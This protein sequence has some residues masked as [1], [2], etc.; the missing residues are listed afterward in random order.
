M[1][2]ARHGLVVGKFYPPHAGHHLLIRA[3]AR[4]CERV[5]VAVLGSSV[6]TMPLDIRAACLRDVHATETNV[7]VVTEADDHRVDYDDP[8][9]WDLHMGVIR[10]AVARAGGAPVDAVFTCE[11]Y[12]A[13]LAR[14]LDA[15]DVCLDLPRQLVPVSGTAVRRDAAAYWSCLAPPVRSWLAR[16]VV[17]AGAEST[18]K[19]TLAAQITETL[20]RRGGAFASCT[21]V[22]E[23]GREYALDKLAS[24]RA[25]AILAGRP[26]ARPEDLAWSRAEFETIA[27]TQVAAEERAAR[28]GGPVLVC[29]TDAFATAIWAERYLGQPAAEVDAI[30]VSTRPHLYLLSD[31]EGAPFVQDGTRDGESVRGWMTRRYVERLEDEGRPYT[32]LRGTLDERRAAGLAAI[33]RLLAAGWGLAPPLA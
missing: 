28:S 17:L 8:R 1:K 31:L 29:D 25:E 6:E 23:F 33:D 5:T 21:W 4:T 2:G 15:R 9:A 20:V 26:P 10:S 11:P 32:W 7:T 30:A 19:T 12:G 3:A 24:A 22:P 13:E 18:G 16:R 27:R 14:R